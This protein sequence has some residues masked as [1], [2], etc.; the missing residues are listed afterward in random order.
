MTRASLILALSSLSLAACAAVAPRP[1]A[2]I[3]QQPTPQEIVAARQ[4]A[5]H[6]TGA[7]MGNV[8]ATIDRGGD[9]KSQAYAARGVARWA[10]ALPGMFP[11]STS[12]VTPTRARP[13]IWANKADFDSRAAAFAAAATELAAAAE[14][15][16]KEAFTAKWRATGATCAACH[17]LYQ[18]PQR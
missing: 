2:A 14:S 12:A 18:V 9:P 16:D 13:E 17:D 4:A 5:F 7:A 3:Q 10:R 8:K 6:M 15:G 1:P 11:Q